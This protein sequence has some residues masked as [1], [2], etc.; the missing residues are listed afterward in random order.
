MDPGL[1]LRE[2]GWLGVADEA[3]GAAALFLLV[4]WMTSGRPRGLGWHETSAALMVNASTLSGMVAMAM[5]RRIRPD[6][7]VAVVLVREEEWD[8]MSV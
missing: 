8:G 5:A 1:T 4:P 7:Y 3:S 6:A 2:Y